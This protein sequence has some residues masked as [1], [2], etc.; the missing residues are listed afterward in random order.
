MRQLDVGNLKLCA[1]TAENRE[2]LTPV[3]LERLA[4]AESQRNKGTTACGLL[5]ALT[6]CPPLPCKGRHPII[7][8]GEAKHHEIGVHLPQRLPLFAR[9]PGIGCQPAR[10]LLGKGIKLAR[11]LRRHELWLDRL[12]VQILLDGVPRQPSAPRDL[13]DWQALP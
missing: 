5:F 8:A 7:G 13:P 4:G 2:V 1:L 11:P 12:F 3:E 10:Q 9:P 6:I